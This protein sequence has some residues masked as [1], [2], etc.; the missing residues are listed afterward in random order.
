LS[1]VFA[2]TEDEISTKIPVVNSSLKGSFEKMA[3][4]LIRWLLTIKSLGAVD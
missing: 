3:V 1:V 2:N 4:A